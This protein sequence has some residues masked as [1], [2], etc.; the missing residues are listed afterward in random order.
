MSE[1]KKWII[2]EEDGTYKGRTCAWSPPDAIPLA[3]RCTSPSK[4]AR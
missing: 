3:V 2:E 1:E 4:T